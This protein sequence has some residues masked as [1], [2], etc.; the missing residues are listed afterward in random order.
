MLAKE[1]QLTRELQRKE[2][3]VAQK[4]AEAEEQ[5]LLELELKRERQRLVHEENQRR[6]EL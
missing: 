6:I 3:K 2:R 4:L 5:R 1:N